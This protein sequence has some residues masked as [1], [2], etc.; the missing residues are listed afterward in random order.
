MFFSNWR[1]DMHDPDQ[2]YQ[3]YFLNQIASLQNLPLDLRKKYQSLIDQGLS[4]LDPV[5]RANIY[6]Q[7]NVFLHDDAPMIILANQFTRHYEPLYID[8]W[9]GSLNQNPMIPPFYYYQLSKQ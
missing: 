8:G 4:E 6:H 9:F 1:E 7:L 3:T 2:W 5:K